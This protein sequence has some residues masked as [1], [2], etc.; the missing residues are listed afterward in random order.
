VPYPTAKGNFAGS[1]TDVACASN[2]GAGSVFGKNDD[3]NGTLTLQVQSILGLPLPTTIT[4]TFN[5]ASG[6]TL[7]AGD[8]PSVVVD[9]PTVTVGVSVS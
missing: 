8:I 9:P 7:T 4:C 5:P 1:G 6:Q 3:D 2:A